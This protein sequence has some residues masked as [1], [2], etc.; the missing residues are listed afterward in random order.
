M[1][2]K[3]FGSR[4]IYSKK[5]ILN[6]NSIHTYIYYCF[7]YF[8]IYSGT[9]FPNTITLN[10]M[11]CTWIISILFFLN[12]DHDLLCFT[13]ENIDIKAPHYMLGS[14]YFR[15]KCIISFTCIKLSYLCKCRKATTVIY[16]VK[17]ARPKTKR[18]CSRKALS[19]IIKTLPFFWGLC[20]LYSNTDSSVHC[21][22][23]L[24]GKFK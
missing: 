4:P 1:F 14:V 22:Q 21:H 24:L 3:Y 2:Y 8:P 5:Y 12:A 16:I 23:L 7:Q 9:V 15:I 10:F 17:D 6:C 20:A 11:Q 13:L 19:L 18:P